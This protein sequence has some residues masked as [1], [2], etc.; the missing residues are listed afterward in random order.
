MM[1]SLIPFTRC[2]ELALRRPLSLSTASR[3][4][5]L[6]LDDERMRGM[7][8]TERQAALQALAQLLL[9]AAGVAMQEAGDDH[10]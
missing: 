6:I 7:K 9:E 10:E 5:D 3:Q 4:L 1:G 8:P 2:R